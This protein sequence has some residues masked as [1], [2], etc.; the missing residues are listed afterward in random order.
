MNVLIRVVILGVRR[1]FGGRASDLVHYALYES[2][3]VL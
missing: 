2:G 3:E 1:P